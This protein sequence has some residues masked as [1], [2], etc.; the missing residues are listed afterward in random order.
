MRECGRA[1]VLIGFM[2]SGKSAVGRALAARLRLRRIDT[3]ELVRGKLGLPISQIFERLG[4]ERF[5]ETETEVL[6]GLSPDDPAIV[7]TGGGIILRAENVQLL[8]RVGTIVCLI[9]DQETLFERVG[10]STSRPLLQTPNPLGTLRQLYAV[11]E[12]LYRAAAD[13]EID[14]SGFSVDEVTELVVEKLAPQDARSM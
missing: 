4:E 14:T 1:I 6:H 3:D 10:R 8:Q 13:L 9:A 2:G 5:R 12:P 7:I 11:R